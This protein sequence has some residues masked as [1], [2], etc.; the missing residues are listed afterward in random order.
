MDF[1]AGITENGIPY[2]T[3]IDEDN[4]NDELIFRDISVD[5]DNKLP[6]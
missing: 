1:I 5:S 6:F 4:E 2:G 3:F